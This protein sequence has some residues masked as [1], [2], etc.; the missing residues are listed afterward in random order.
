[1]SAVL[2]RSTHH[3]G[4]H[5]T[6]Q[7]GTMVHTRDDSQDKARVFPLGDGF[8][9]FFLFSISSQQPVVREEREGGSLLPS[10]LYSLYLFTVIGFVL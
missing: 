6:V 7:Y 1:M 5:G 8:F 2:P 3:P 10:A 4:L 9:L